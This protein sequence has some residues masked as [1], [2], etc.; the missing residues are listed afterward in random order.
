MKPSDLPKPRTTCPACVSERKVCEETLR[1]KLPDEQLHLAHVALVTAVRTPR[2]AVMS[3][4]SFDCGSQLI[5]RQAE[6]AF[7]I[8][9]DCGCVYVKYWQVMEAQAVIRPQGNGKAG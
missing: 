6:P 3:P 9:A 1:G 5:Q 4:A 8:C 2:G 7:E